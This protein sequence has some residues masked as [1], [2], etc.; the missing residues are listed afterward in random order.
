MY[1]RQGRIRG[2]FVEE[3]GK[4]ISGKKGGERDKTGNTER[5]HGQSMEHTRMTSGNLLFCTIV[6]KNSSIGPKTL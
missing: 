3:K 1:V 5:N 4:G 6:L 2:L